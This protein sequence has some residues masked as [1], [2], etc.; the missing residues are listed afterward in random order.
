VP[1]G[2]RA[3]YLL[4]INASA[5]SQSHTPFI[6][7]RGAPMTSYRPMVRY[8]TQ[9]GPRLRDQLLLLVAPNGHAGAG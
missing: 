6:S 7:R 9:N 3:A 2:K 4:W 8:W 5:I 1:P